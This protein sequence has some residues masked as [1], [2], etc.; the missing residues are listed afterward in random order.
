MRVTAGDA[1]VAAAAAAVVE[2]ETREAVR[3]RLEDE[4]PILPVASLYTV[5]VGTFIDG[6]VP[7]PAASERLSDAMTLGLP[8]M[9]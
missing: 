1:A 5:C 7:M 9:T 4:A 8:S 6:A 3:A 2:A